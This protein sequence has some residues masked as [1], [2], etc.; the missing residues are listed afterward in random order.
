MPSAGL[1][2]LGLQ[3]HWFLAHRLLTR[4]RPEYL[5]YAQSRLLKAYF[6]FLD[7]V[8]VVAVSSF[9][10]LENFESCTRQ[11]LVSCHVICR[12]IDH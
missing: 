3:L 12:R 8:E 2:L 6:S 4:D 5:A 10:L 1:D 11:H 9:V 7:G